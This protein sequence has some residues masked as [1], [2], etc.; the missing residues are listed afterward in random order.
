M[1]TALVVLEPGSDHA[2]P[3][4]AVTL[5][6]CGSLDHAP[7]CPLAPHHTAVQEA[8]DHTALRVLFAAEPADEDDVRQRIE[9]ALAG[10]AVEG[11]DG[12]T[13]RWTLVSAGPGELEPSEAQHAGRLVAGA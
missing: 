8:G 3:G 2:A 7:P 12:R 13:S 10:G 6:L 9:R 1:H 5:A 11:P 4:A